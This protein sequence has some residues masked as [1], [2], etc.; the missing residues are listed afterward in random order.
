[1][2]THP[3][4]SATC[5]AEALPTSSWAGLVLGDVPHSLVAGDI[6]HV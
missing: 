4:T 2:L 1:M 6:F 5:L 3:T